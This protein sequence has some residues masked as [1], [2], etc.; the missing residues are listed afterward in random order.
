[1]KLMVTF[2]RPC[3]IGMDSDSK[4]ASVHGARGG[5]LGKGTREEGCS[6]GRE[7]GGGQRWGGLGK[8]GWGDRGVQSNGGGGGGRGRA[9]VCVW[10]GGE[11]VT[12]WSG[13]GR[14]GALLEQAQ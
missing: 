6:K 5:V 10:G 11:V 13:E 14:C 7:V 3:P 2:T 1:M 9:E 12:G 8:G 4:T